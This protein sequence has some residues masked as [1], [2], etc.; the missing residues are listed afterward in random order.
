MSRSTI[1]LV[2][3][4]LAALI[5][6][7]GCTGTQASPQADQK[8]GASGPQQTTAGVGSAATGDPDSLA[9]PV[10]FQPESIATGSLD[11]RRYAYT[12][13]LAGGSIYRLDLDTGEG[14]EITPPTT[15]RR[16]G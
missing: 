15:R 2:G 14:K 10:G 12:A 9:L 13:S 4:A 7:A 6:A 5:F 11:G 8:D 1:K 16:W 3:L